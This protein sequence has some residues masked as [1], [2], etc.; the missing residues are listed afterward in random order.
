M[1]SVKR[2]VE[3]ARCLWPGIHRHAEAGAGRV[4]AIHGNNED[5]LAPRRVHRI[6][7]CATHED[8]VLGR[9]RMQF[10]RSDA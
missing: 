3:P 10:T 7:E 1:T 4:S 5:I 9:D 6:D 2:E 8:L